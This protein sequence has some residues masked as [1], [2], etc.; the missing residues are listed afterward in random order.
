MRTVLA[1]ADMRCARGSRE[2]S[3]RGAVRVVNPKVPGVGYPGGAGEVRSFGHRATPNRSGSH[4]TAPGQTPGRPREGLGLQPM[5][6]GRGRIELPGSRRRG[7]Y[8]PWAHHLPN[9]PTR[10]TSRPARRPRRERRLVCQF[11]RHRAGLQKPARPRRAAPRAPGRTGSGSPRLVLD[12]R[13]EQPHELRIELRA[14]LAA[15]LVQGVGD[16]AGRYGRSWMIAS[17][18]STRPTMRAPTGITSPR[19]PSG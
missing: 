18:A 14:G 13:E 2:L 7:F 12:H 11:P 3:P 4:A 1:G 8:R 6:V 16:R 17:N 5:L 9:R 19:S 10:L 15:Q